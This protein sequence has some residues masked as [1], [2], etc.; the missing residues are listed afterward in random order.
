MRRFA[1]FLLNELKLFRT[2]VPIHLI[3]ILQPTVLYGVMSL[4]LVHPTFDVRV[5]PPAT[6]EGRALVAAMRQVGSP[7]GEPYINPMIVEDNT[8]GS[9]QVVS[10]ET[11]NGTPT[12]VQR[13]GFIDSNQVKNYRNR[14]TAAALRLWNA[15]LGDRAVTV[16]E[17]PWLSRDMPYTIYFGMA[18]LP[19]TAFLAAVLIGGVL[20]AQ[21]FE[22][23]TIVEYRLAPVSPAHILGA[24]LVRLVLSGLLSGGVLLVAVGAITGAWPDSLWRVGLTLLPMA[25]MGGS[26]GIMAGLLLRSTIPTFLVGLGTSLAGWLLGSAFG[27]AAGFSGPYETVSRLMPNTHAVELL[28]PRYYGTE[29][30]TPTVSMAVLVGSSIVLATLAVLAYR[31]RVL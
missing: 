4:I 9:I 11:R 14:L 5:T 22:F 3:A 26:L 27:L 20:T 31:W 24:R 21:D 23:Q 7:I 15:A 30:G 29:I 10:V 28:F 2:A 19:M 12:A 18:L 13:F 6:D 8:G 17:F 25:I 1:L 16:E